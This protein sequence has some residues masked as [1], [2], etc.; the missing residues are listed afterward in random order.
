MT[1]SAV[2]HRQILDLL[3][4]SKEVYVTRL[5]EALQVSEMT[6]RRDLKLLEER[7]RLTRVHGGAV[8]SETAVPV[9]LIDRADVQREAKETIAQLAVQLI[10]PDHH[11]LITGSSTTLVLAEYL[12][13]GPRAH[14]VTNLI[15][16]ALALSG[17]GGHDAVLTGGVLRPSM[18]TLIG[19]EM[20][21]H[22]EGRVF[23]L[24]FIGVKAIDLEHGFLGPTEWHAYAQ[25]VVRRQC[26]CVV[27]LTDHTKFGAVSSFCVAG[28]GDMDVLV[29]DRPPPPE[30][31]ARF[32]QLGTRLIWPGSEGAANAGA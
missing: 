19:T 11:V 29:T 12:V 7:G 4:D 24:C 1:L 16:I 26:R 14:Y 31:R 28:L 32:D 3:N 9:S 17:P 18:R 8:T 27:A 2:R 10:E 23:D 13:D 22:I 25:R 6:I 15:D 21:R 30:F 5:A 20:L